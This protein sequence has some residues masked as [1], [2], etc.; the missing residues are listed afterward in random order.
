MS[1]PPRV[2]V[3]GL[4]LHVYLRGHNRNVVFH[5]DSDYEHFLWL[6]GDSTSGNRVDV[7]G[8]ALMGN[9]YHAVVTPRHETALSL[10]MKELNRSY[11]RYYNKK[12]G[13]MGTVW[14]GRYN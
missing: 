12:Y 14:N 11:V 2:Y 6:V 10:A 7:H 1:R 3:P 5:D 9:H 13:R 8:Y 4:S